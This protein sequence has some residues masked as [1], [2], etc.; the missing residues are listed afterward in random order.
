VPMRLAVIGTDQLV[1][2]SQAKRTLA[3]I[4]KFKFVVLDFKGV[5]EIGQAFADEIFRVYAKA[6]PEIIIAPMNES[7][8]VAAMISRARAT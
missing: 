2:R 3:R 6:H 7:K 5:S 4:E 8:A 1:S